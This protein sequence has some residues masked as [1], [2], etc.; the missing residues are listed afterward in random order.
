MLRY[1]LSTSRAPL[2]FDRPALAT[3]QVPSRLL[4][5]RAT[6]AFTVGS[7]GLLPF[8]LSLFHFVS[9]LLSRASTGSIAR[10][11]RLNMFG[12][13]RNVRLMGLA[14]FLFIVGFLYVQR[15]GQTD[16][17]ESWNP[18]KVGGGS[19]IR[20][21]LSDIPPHENLPLPQPKPQPQPEPEPQV[22][23]KPDPKSEPIVAPEPKPA[24]APEPE[25]PVEPQ[26]EIPLVPVDVKPP[27]AKVETTSAA[28]AYTSSAALQ[29]PSTIPAPLADLYSSPRPES[30][31][32]GLDPIA[33]GNAPGRVDVT[34]SAHPTQVKTR[35]TKPIENYPISSTI[36]LPTGTPKPF[37]RIQRA[38]KKLSA[39]GADQEKLAAVKAAADHAWSGYRKMAFGSDEIR[40]VSG[41]FNNP[42]NGWG[43]SLI[44]ALDSLW[45]MG[46]TE[47]FEEAL[48][49][50][51]KTDFT[52]S[53]RADIPVFETTIRYLG[54]LIAA[55][56]VSG[57]KYR[58]L[59]DKA[60]ELAEVLYGIFDTPNRMPQTYYR[61][62]PAQVARPT[63]AGVRAVL[64][65]IGTLD[66][67]FTRLAQL[68]GEPKYY[69]AVARITDA[70]EEF[71]NRT[72]LPGMWPTTLDASGCGKAPQGISQGYY[73]HGYGGGS[74][75]QNRNGSNHDMLSGEATTPD[76][77]PQRIPN[78][79]LKDLVAEGTPARG[80]DHEDD[81]L[82]KDRLTHEVS[83]KKV[84]R[85]LAVEPAAKPG[86]DAVSYKQS[87]GDQSSS[88]EKP[89][90]D[91]AH[92]PHRNVPGV[93]DDGCVPQGLN[94]TSRS[95][96]ESYTLG[97]ASDSLYEYLPKQHILLG[98]LVDKY[99]TMYLDSAAVMIQ[100]LL[101]KP[102]LPDERDIL[103]SGNLKMQPNY[104]SPEH[105]RTYFS[106]LTPELEHLSCFAG[107]MFA[108]GGVLFDEPEHV[109]IGAKLTDGC[110][111][112]YSVMPTG[113]MPETSLLVPCKD[114]WGDCPYNQTL[115]WEL[116]DPYEH[117]R[118]GAYQGLQHA[119]APTADVTV[120]AEGNK[121]D[122]SKRDLLDELDE[123]DIGPQLPP[124]PPSARVE[125][126]ESPAAQPAL[127]DVM[128]PQAPQPQSA[129][130]A[131]NPDLVQ[132]SGDRED[133]LNIPVY[134]PPPPL[135]HK[136][137]VEQKISDERLPP[138]FVR[139]T[140]RRYLLRP[141][142]IESVFY[143]YRITGDMYWRKVGWNMFTS[144][145]RHT[146]ALYGA[147]A[148]D[149]VT[150]AAPELVDEQESFWLAETLKYFYL[151]FDDPD[152]WSLDDWVF[153]TEAHLF[154]RPAYE[155]ADEGK[156]AKEAQG[157]K[158]AK[159]A[160]VV[161]EEGD[162][163][164]P[165]W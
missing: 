159:K 74:S 156:D 27:A 30:D 120:V 98:G 70:L 160:K 58:I 71:Q 80:H 78:R 161:A 146:R 55:Y 65:E 22:E 10:R 91:S 14:A 158:E 95:S 101:F 143:M 144:I 132:I 141:E 129:P 61:W 1:R 3:R 2:E 26:P 87:I 63:R 104:S 138:G 123:E 157:P 69:D 136:E 112:A 41:L 89:E 149:D 6:S 77:P 32:L 42:F 4:S 49:I 150:K 137:Y 50:V 140:G 13:N 142:A 47:E 76:L 12:R 152:K 165:G 56:D 54:G 103:I 45:I 154:R 53:L 20:P 116:L 79:R 84:K 9:S 48:T 93:S 90:M 40:P 139:I 97:G 122:L 88:D 100:N 153:N 19:I 68:T 62:M 75:L 83:N 60:V 117:S 21:K 7:T 18:D 25:L 31:D 67:E 155:L 147:S 126:S 118:L 94:S 66:L 46:K 109:E 108:M 81:G 162:E 127:P 113:I 163:R 59:L 133:N 39:N 111:W 124:P 135:S 8:H 35:Y 28:T 34:T 119:A 5:T 114:T 43:A 151:L 115:Y 82:N 86:S 130:V 33:A 64:A 57:K 29:A 106:K 164:A 128:P 38:T 24:V 73:G 23:L 105:A 44:D 102:M 125:P 110:V 72:R 11:S 134:V 107:G 16:H 51:G 37:P 145:E 17:F 36:Q 52:W 85:Q 96:Q 121:S 15:G 148:I 99:R 131:S 92:V